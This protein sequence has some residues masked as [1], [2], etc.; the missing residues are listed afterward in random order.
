MLKSILSVHALVL[1][2][3]PHPPYLETWAS[4]WH[5]CPGVQRDPG[6]HRSQIRRSH[7]PHRRSKV[8]SLDLLWSW[9]L[10]R[11]LDSKEKRRDNWGGRGRREG[12]GGRRSSSR[13]WG[14]GE[15]GDSGKDWGVPG[16]SHCLHPCSPELRPLS[17]SRPP[18]SRLR[19]PSCWPRSQMSPGKAS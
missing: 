1:R 11:S 5:R 15:T 6:V 16:R 8:V 4:H 3:Q 2:A 19:S 17:C 10:H 7:C 18:D 12:G 14:P 9:G 13:E